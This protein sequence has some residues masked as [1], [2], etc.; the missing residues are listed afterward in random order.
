MKEKNKGVRI[1]F[2]MIVPGILILLLAAGIH[3]DEY[4]DIDLVESPPL[5]IGEELESELGG[6]KEPDFSFHDTDTV[7][8]TNREKAPQVKEFE[9]ITLT[10][11]AP[12][13]R[14]ADFLKKDG[15]AWA[16]QNGVNL[17]IEEIPFS[18]IFQK[19]Y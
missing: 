18:K 3:R 8:L 16:V 13:D 9:G 6:F 14:M 1:P 10:V 7:V 11:A 17:K 5:K 12:Q 2:L 15:T 4:G 19:T